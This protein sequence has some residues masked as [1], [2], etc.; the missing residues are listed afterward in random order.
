MQ[1][2]IENGEAAESVKLNEELIQTRAQLSDLTKELDNYVEVQAP[3]KKPTYPQEGVPEK[4]LEWIDVHPEFKTDELFYV[5][6]LTVSKQLIKEGYD[7]K[8][9]DFYEELDARLSPRF[10]ELFGM[11]EENVVK[12]DNKDKNPNTS[13]EDEDENKEP[14]SSNK[15]QTIPEQ[16]VSGASR[17]STQ[18]RGTQKRGKDS[19]TLSPTDVRQAERFG[20][21]L[22][23]Y[24]RRIAHNSKN[25]RNDG[26]VEIKLKK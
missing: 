21:S 17:A 16:T 11:E 8:S 10:P 4:A 3:P 12:Y 9:D 2:A 24:A 5:S 6:S 26:Y 22:E 1:D 23:Q 20:L 25:R 18:S 7:D 14:S 15:R 13:N 19:V